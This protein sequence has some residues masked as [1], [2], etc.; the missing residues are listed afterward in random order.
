V[1]NKA[2]V[3]DF[4]TSRRAK[5]SP[6]QAGVPMYGDRRRV[7][8]LRREEVAQ[9]A[10]LSTDYYTR[11]EKGSL[12]SAS[13]SVL[14]AVARALQLDDA[15]RAHLHDLARA[16]RGGGRP[17]RR[18]PQPQQL[19]QSLQHMLDA[20]VTVPA[21]INNGR[22]DL[23][24]A[25]ALAR[26]FYTEVLDS[27]T[28]SPNFARYCFLDL[29]AR[30]FYAD[31]D[32]AADTTTNML[33]TEAGRDPHNRALSDLIGE[34]A[35]RSDE[36]RVRWARHDVHV[37]VMGSKTFRHPVVGELNLAFN[38]VPLPGDPGLA[39]T[40]YTP[41]PGTGTDERLALLASWAATPS[42]AQR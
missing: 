40:V 42:A 2:E 17:V 24:G 7:P 41:E 18:R 6:Q 5:L 39:L 22:L 4:L 23:V 29:R 33:R 37:H 16:A 36:F 9:L 15:E 34:L 31:W 14:E 19:R 13:E 8:G 1:D 21:F 20:M 35:T 3:R 30:E 12:S 32:R 38:T 25:N 28:G 27:P 26:A 10:G 11:L